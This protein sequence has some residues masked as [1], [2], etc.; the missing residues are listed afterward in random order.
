MRHQILQ[1][2]VL[3]VAVGVWTAAGWSADTPEFRS[4]PCRW[5]DVARV[6]AVGDVHGVCEQLVKSLKGAVVIDE[7][8]NWMAGKSH[9]VQ[10]GDIPDRGPES[11]RAMDLLMKLEKQ[12]AEAGGMVHPLLGNHEIMVMS[13]DFRYAHPGE[14]QAFGGRAGYQKALGREG[15]YGKWLRGHNTVIIINDVMFMHGGMAAHWG[16]LTIQ[17]MNDHIRKHLLGLPTP[18]GGALLGRHGPTWYRGWCTQNGRSVAEQCDDLFRKF[19]VQHAVVGHTPQ[20]G[21]TV[22]GFGRVVGIDSGMCAAYGGPA[23]ALVIEAGKYFA[24]YPGKGLI[25]LKVHYN[26]RQQPVTPPPLKKAG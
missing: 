11:R 20:R 4:Q 19:G 8:E 14:F 18:H 21:I 23:S 5:T 26:D 22:F 12:A 3:A 1:L 17:Q 25:P 2:F 15:E 13:S 10:T 16:K 6:V 7:Q 9:L 24:A